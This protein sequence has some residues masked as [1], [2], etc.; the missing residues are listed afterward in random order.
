[1]KPKTISLL[2]KI[3]LLRKAY[4]LVTDFRDKLQRMA[5]VKYRKDKSSSELT[6]ILSFENN[7]RMKFDLRD[8]YNWMLYHKM[9]RAKNLE[10]S[11][12]ELVRRLLKPGDV[13]V[14]IGANIGY[15]TLLA[16][17]LVGSGGK[18]YSFEPS[19][20]TYVRL[21]DNINL[22]SFHNIIPYRLA[23]SD[24]LSIIKIYIDENSQDLNS[25]Y[26]KTDKFIT[27][28]AYP[29]EK[30]CKGKID[31]I[32]ID[33]EGCEYEALRGMRNIVIPK[34]G[35][36]SRTKIIIELNPSFTSSDFFNYLRKEFEIYGIERNI[37]RKLNE[38]KR[39]EE[40]NSGNV[41]LIP[42]IK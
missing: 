11:S 1:M 41:L 17:S 40:I 15:Y 13:F 14:D 5:F 28:S 35:D 22:N 24:K 31:L 32:K 10:P 8:Y 38:I 9:I 16:A 7:L 6:K 29:L 21:V 36:I 23:I 18:V 20:Q 39:M 30:I 34:E 26:R 12:T 2:R 4:N 27:V 3:P 42:K 25:I 33:C 37:N 19:P